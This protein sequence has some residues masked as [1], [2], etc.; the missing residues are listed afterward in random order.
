VKADDNSTQPPKADAL[1]G[2]GIQD[3][4]RRFRREL[5]A[6][7]SVTGALITDVDRASNSFEAGLRP[8]DVITEINHQP[9]VNADD[10]VRLCKAALTQ[11]ILV[12][13][14]HPEPDGGHV[15]YLSVDNT[16]RHQ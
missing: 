14:W 10:A 9:V 8:G 2:V 1:D 7:Q 13:I 12:K 4:D 3:L 11:Q 6:P 5:H 15:R 16:K